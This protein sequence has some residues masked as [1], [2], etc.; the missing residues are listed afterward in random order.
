MG[1]EVPCRSQIIGDA[2]RGFCHDSGDIPERWPRL[3]TGQRLK[4]R[5]RTESLNSRRG[6]ADVE[7]MRLLPYRLL[8]ATAVSS[9][10][11][12]LSVW[13][14]VW[15]DDELL[16]VAVLGL[17]AIHLA[18]LGVAITTDWRGTMRQLRAFQ[19]IQGRNKGPFWRFVCRDTRLWWRS[20]GIALAATGVVW[21][22]VAV[23]I[24]R[25]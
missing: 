25:W 8:T 16:V 17:T 22:V 11:A 2:T 14:L 6:S 23:Q 19:R 18:G 4:A 21:A 3:G 10:L 15:W 24:A 12:M 13:S 1:G 20:N 9:C 7:V 5:V